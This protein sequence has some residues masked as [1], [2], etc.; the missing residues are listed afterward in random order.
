MKPVEEAAEV[1]KR[2]Q[3]ARTFREDLEAH[4]LNGMVIS[5]REFF[6]MARKVDSQAE[7]SDIV[8]PWVNNFQK[9]NCWHLYLY[10]GNMSNAFGSADVR[11]PFVSFERRNKLKIY[12]WDVI[13]QRTERFF[14]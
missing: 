7:P 5:N 12:P 6:L 10:A 14:K 13:F 8:D 4:L 11:L 1:Y 9:F 2:E 3:C